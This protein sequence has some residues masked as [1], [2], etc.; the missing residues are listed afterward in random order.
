MGTYVRFYDLGEED[1][2]NLEY[3]VNWERQSFPTMYALLDDLGI[4]Y[5]VREEYVDPDFSNYYA[6]VNLK[7]EDV[8]RIRNDNS[9]L[10]RSLIK[11]LD[12]GKTKFTFKVV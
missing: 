7:A 5:S 6:T 8:E 12:K 2:D 4:T 3:K 9:E 1:E 10:A 11:V